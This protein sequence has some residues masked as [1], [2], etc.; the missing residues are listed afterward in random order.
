MR[1]YKLISTFILVIVLVG[2]NNNQVEES[3]SQ[4]DEKTNVVETQRENE[5]ENNEKNPIPRQFEKN[6]VIITKEVVEGENSLLDVYRLNTDT[7][8]EIKLLTL[9]DAYLNHYHHQESINNSLYIVR[10][11]IDDNSSESDWIDELWRYD[12]S[13]EGNKLFSAQGLDFRVSPN[14]EHIAIV[15]NNTLFFINYDGEVLNGIEIKNLQISNDESWIGPNGWSTDSKYFWG[16]ISM[17]VLNYS[18]YKVDVQTWEINKYDV[19]DL[20]Y[21]NEYDFN[22]NTE[23]FIYSDYP[24]LLDID[25]YN[26]FIDNK[27]VVNLHIYDFS[28]NAEKIIASSITKEFNPKWIDNKTV[29]FN[30]PNN[31]ERIIYSL[32]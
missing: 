28:T 4:K 20:S 27:T 1:K 31:D 32:E 7:S 25:D 2:C 18:L 11:I 5:N 6:V 23:L 22:P 26:M 30:N 19:S 10:R 24:A 14:E 12:S 21:H 17:T 13:G 16:N 29:E 15:S 9:N 3:I 8:E